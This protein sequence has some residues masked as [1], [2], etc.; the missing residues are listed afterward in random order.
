MWL[1]IKNLFRQKEELRIEKSPKYRLCKKCNRIYPANLTFFYKN[2]ERKDG[3][4]TYCKKCSQKLRKE[5]REK[6]RLQEARRS[7]K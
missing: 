5:R 3:L 1:W 2:K 7:K 4:Y 6:K